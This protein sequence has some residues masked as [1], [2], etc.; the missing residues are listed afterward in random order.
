ML[1]NMFCLKFFEF[2]TLYIYVRT[3]RA[4]RTMC[5]KCGGFITV[6]PKK[7]MESAAKVQFVQGLVVETT[8]FALGLFEYG[9]GEDYSTSAGGG[10]KR[11]VI[12]GS[13]KSEKETPEEAVKRIIKDKIDVDEKSYLFDDLVNKYS[14]IKEAQPDLD[15][16]LI[17]LRLQNYVKGQEYRAKE[18]EWKRTIEQLETEIKNSD[19]YKNLPDDKKDDYLKM[20]TSKFLKDKYSETTIGFDGKLANIKLFGTQLVES[21]DSNC[22]NKAQAIEILQEQLA[23]EYQ[24]KNNLTRQEALAKAK[25]YIE[26]YVTDAGKLESITNDKNNQTLEATIIREVL[27]KVKAY[28]I[29]GDLSLS[30]EEATRASYA[31]AS[32]STDDNQVDISDYYRFGA[33]TVEGQ[34][35]ITTSLNEAGDALGVKNFNL[36]TEF[37]DFNYKKIDENKGSIT[38]AGQELPIEFRDNKFYIKFGEN[39]LEFDS[40]ELLKISVAD[41]AQEPV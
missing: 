33:D 27:A 23:Q 25:E 9:F 26:T 31:G 20:Q 36:E 19:A 10:S 17:L 16:S 11:T 30:Y 38:I 15:E 37:K 35:D 8:S 13:E 14:A 40:L 29:D 39:E 7:A 41:L 22:D 2:Q 34:Q 4:S 28:D 6:D 21:V 24:L 12:T 32:Y 3:V 1:Q 18:T 5:V